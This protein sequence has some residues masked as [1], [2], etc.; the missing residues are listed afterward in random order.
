M[1]KLN[2]NNTNKIR[3]QY[4]INPFSLYY[5]CDHFIGDEINIF[6]IIIPES[7][8]DILSTNDLSVIKDFDIIHV[9]VNYFKYFCDKIINKIDKKIILS[10]GQW[11]LPQIHPSKLTEM[12]INHPNI[13]LWISQ[14][15]IYP[16]S[17]KYIA[18]PYGID[19]NS[20]KNYSTSEKK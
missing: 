14:N 4:I 3:L 11:H 1:N 6:N 17:K 2:Y 16:N 18:F 20:L 5:L 8:N 13:L 9:Q 7:K 10:T 15:P 19:T 12:I